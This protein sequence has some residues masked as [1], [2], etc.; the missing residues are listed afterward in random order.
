MRTVIGIFLSLLLL[1]FANFAGADSMRVR[2]RLDRL[3]TRTPIPPMVQTVPVG[4]QAKYRRIAVSNRLAMVYALGDDA[5]L[6]YALGDGR[7][8]IVATV[9]CPDADDAL[10][11]D[12]ERGLLYVARRKGAIA[13]Y[14][15]SPE[16]IPAT[17]VALDSGMERVVRLCVNAR[18]HHLYAFGPGNLQPLAPMKPPSDARIIQVPMMYTIFDAACDPAYQRLYVCT[19]FHANENI[20][21]WSLAPD[22]TLHNTGPKS[23]AE[24]FPLANDRPRGYLATLVV[25]HRKGRLY[26]GGEAENSIKETWI[27][28][29]TL[30]A[31]GDPAGTPRCQAGATAR[32]G[33]TALGISGDGRWLYETGWDN[34]PR[35]FLHALDDTGDMT[36]Q[37]QWW[38]VENSY[39]GH[40]EETKDRRQLI[41]GY[42]GTTFG[43]IRLQPGGEPV[44]AV[45]ATFIAGDRRFDAGYL[46]EGGQSPW[47]PLDTAQV[48]RCDLSLTGA[49]IGTARLTFEVTGKEEPANTFHTVV[50]G[51]KTALLLSGGNQPSIQSTVMRAEQHLAWARQW[52]LSPEERPRSILIA[53]SLFG[54]DASPDALEKELAALGTIGHNTVSIGGA[55]AAISF[56][57]VRDAAR[58][59][60]ISHKYSIGRNPLT[61]LDFLY[62]GRQPGY[63]EALASRLPLSLAGDAG[64]I[65][66]SDDPGWYRPVHVRDGARL[67]EVFSWNCPHP[68][69]EG[70]ADPRWFGAFRD[71]LVGRGMAPA[72]FRQN[73]WEGVQT[74]LLHPGGSLPER[75][76]SYWVSRFIE[77]AR[78]ET[79]A[80]ITMALDRQSGHRVQTASSLANVPDAFPLPGSV[81]GYAPDWFL[82]GRAH[83]VSMLWFGDWMGDGSLPSLSFHASLLRCA[84]AAGAISF[85]ASITA[86]LLKSRPDAG[87]FAMLALAGQG[88]HAIE[89]YAFGPGDAVVSGWSEDPELYK[90]VADGLRLLGKSESLLVAGKPRRG[91]VALLHPSSATW[92]GP[93]RRGSHMPGEQYGLHA[94]LIHAQYPV[95]F[96]DEIA[97]ERGALK[98]YAAL[99]V[100][101]RQLTRKT[102][103]AIMDWVRKGGTAVLS[104]G[105][106]MADEYNEPCPVLAGMAR[107]GK[108][109]LIVLTGWRGER[110]WNSQSRGWSSADREA[111]VAPLR[112]A[113][114]EKYIRVSAPMVE[115]TLLES[116]RGLAVP[117][118]NWSGKPLTRITVTLPIP[119]T[120]NYTIRSV[121]C[122]VLPGVRK[123]NCMTISLPLHTIDVLMLEPTPLTCE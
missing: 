95:D 52:A 64:F 7:E 37:V 27:T 19:A 61:D 113:G 99:Y 54:I 119:G 101:A 114:A 2:A 47:I 104:P 110:Y 48:N 63:L 49:D 82:L 69:A 86:R 105:T 40:L 41:L 30:D 1:E 72:F 6:A 91:T 42:Y 46:P 56:S 60:G 80:A 106:G 78:V 59:A 32:A 50:Q 57:S 4:Q 77:D 121:E 118:L 73:N 17:A 123:G 92:L 117:L 120:G 25:D 67:Q 90:S 98:G 88:V 111:I 62:A 44:R 100:S 109:R 84:A 31:R 96:L 102:R 26:V 103:N 39:I 115:T 94:A 122:G 36:G 3:E 79:L 112:H 38:P 74:M 71:Y 85:G 83:A 5:V 45:T 89:P 33:L 28:T 108:G 70:Q 53:N 87:K 76:L 116:P 51:N 9:P 13:A 23:Y 68:S 20:W 8:R 65:R 97:I 43:I 29:Y 93:D 14:A 24:G 75:R 15:L 81:R 107:T 55:Y 66:L 58:Q 10:A 12:D 34:Q 21:V 11:L 18:T 16:G 22:G 35:I